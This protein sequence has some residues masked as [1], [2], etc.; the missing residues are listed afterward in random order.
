MSEQKKRLGLQLPVL[1]NLLDSIILVF[2]RR[3]V[4]F[5][6]LR[7]L[8]LLRKTMMWNIHWILGRYWRI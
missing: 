7:E 6:S 3:S 4:I 8:H 1:M 5:F 2:K